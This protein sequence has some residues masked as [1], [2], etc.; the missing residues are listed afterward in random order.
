M[1]AASTPT[2][3]TPATPAEIDAKVADRWGW[4]LALGI[5]YV[6]LGTFGLIAVGPLSLASALVIAALFLI[7][8]VV[9]LVQAFRC[10]GWRSTAVHV[11]GAVLYIVAGALLLAQPLIGLVTITLAIGAI[12]FAAGV[13][14]LVIA[15]QHRPDEGWTWLAVSGVVGILLGLV[16]LAGLPG[17]ALW[18]LG[19]LVA[20]ELLMEGWSMIM[21]SLALRRWKRTAA[22]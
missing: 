18:V 11:L 7:G 9:Q 2:P 4:F 13:T 10:S 12:I 17:N 5:L 1:N 8:G 6:L 19:L 3:A 21:M 14:R 22:A 15:F 20:V 16:I